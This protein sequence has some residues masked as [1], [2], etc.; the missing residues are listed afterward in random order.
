[1]IKPKNL[2]AVRKTTS[3]PKP[4]A[5]C[6]EAKSVYNDS[7]EEKQISQSNNLKPEK[8]VPAVPSAQFDSEQSIPE[9]DYGDTEEMDKKLEQIM[10]TKE[11]TTKKMR[12]KL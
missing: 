8:L 6:K 9:R 4:T 11:L 3:S 10:N 1:M 5:E 2:L 12:E 7:D